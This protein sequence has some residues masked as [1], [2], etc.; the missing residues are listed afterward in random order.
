M[1]EATPKILI[2][3][4]YGVFGG[5]LAQ[6]LA[7]EPRVTLVIAGRSLEKARA[8]CASLP[9]AAPCV[10]LAFDRDGDVA[11]QLASIGPDL[12][13]DASGPFQAYSGDVYKLVRAAIAVGADYMDLADSSEF[14]V[15]I[16]AFDSEARASGVYVLAGVSS[17]PVLTAAVV[18]KLAG[19]SARV[20]AIR[21]GI[22]PSPFARVG[23]NVIRAIASY[24]GQKVA[25]TRGG[26]GA[27]A[28]GLTETMRRAVRPPG[29]LPLESRLFSLVDVPDLRAL[30][31]LWPGL[32]SIWV[33]AAPAPEV[34]HRALIALAWLV[35]WRLSP[36]LAPLAPLF[37]AALARSCAGA[38]IAAACSSRSRDGRIGTAR[39]ALLAYAG[40]GR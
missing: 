27:Q 30:P 37:H 26:V 32:R 17:F 29:M 31:P 18:R 20:A 39:P 21:A 5:R 7:T 15:G 38:R 9:G 33:G 14:V 19:G 1:S 8:F 6:L 28:Y 36:N 35:R 34:L 2:L 16:G 22:A 13:V 11:A 12:V 40:R 10:A 25:L 23:P 3:G 24:A 4:G